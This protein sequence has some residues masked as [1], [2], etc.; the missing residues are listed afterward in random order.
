MNLFTS[1][2]SGETDVWC[3]KDT[4]F[5]GNNSFYEEKFLKI[6]WKRC[7]HG[8][9][10]LTT[11]LQKPISGFW[12]RLNISMFHFYISFSRRDLHFRKTFLLILSSSSDSRNANFVLPVPISLFPLSSVYHPNDIAVSLVNRWRVE[13]LQ[14][15]DSGVWLI[16]CFHSIYIQ[17]HCLVF[18]F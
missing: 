18:W 3:C 17:A 8:S 16:L 5:V 6:R 4:Q 15:N 12:N 14:V 1:V 7:P 9:I 10:C 2:S 13:R 11:V